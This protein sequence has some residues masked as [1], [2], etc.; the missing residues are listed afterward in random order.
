MTDLLSGYTPGGYYCELFGGDG[1]PLEHT[2]A[3]RNWLADLPLL[4]GPV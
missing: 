4:T 1:A 3:I 2:Q